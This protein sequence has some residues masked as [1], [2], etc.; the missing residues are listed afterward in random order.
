MHLPG[1]PHYYVKGDQ[2]R[3]VYYTAD[4]RELLQAGWLPEEKAVESEPFE[5]EEL[6]IEEEIEDQNEAS[7]STSFSLTAED[8]EEEPV[9]FESMTKVELMEYA[10]KHG[11]KLQ[12]A[13]SKA[14]M[15]EACEKL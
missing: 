3:A 13:M 7:I 9:D 12:P 10:V 6:D 5:P 8:T 15:V 4:A 2:R 1:Y 11:S 14:E